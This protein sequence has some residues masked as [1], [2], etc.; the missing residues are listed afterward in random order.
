MFDKAMPS[1]VSKVC[2][3][4][5]VR[6]MNHCS[7]SGARASGYFV[8][9]DMLYWMDFPWVFDINMNDSLYQDVEK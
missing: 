1:W 3:R 4:M 8:Q 9:F 7:H 5:A 6:V 2:G